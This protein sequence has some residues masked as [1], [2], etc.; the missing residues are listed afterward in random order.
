MRNVKTFS[1][2]TYNG[3]VITRTDDYDPSYP[4]TIYE[5]YSIIY[6]DEPMGKG[7]SL[8]DC[9]NQIDERIFNRNLARK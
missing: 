7:I 3:F 8:T 6:R 1:M 2:G 5:F 9:K 4:S